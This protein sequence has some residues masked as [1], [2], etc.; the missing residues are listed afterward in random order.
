MTLREFCRTTDMELCIHYKE[1]GVYWA[2][3]T[4]SEGTQPIPDKL[5]NRE[6]IDVNAALDPWDEI[7]LEITLKSLDK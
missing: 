6:V 1:D 3:Y 4:K 2:R 7:F 5:L